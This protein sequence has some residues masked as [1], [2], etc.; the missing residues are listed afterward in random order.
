LSSD[1]LHEL[2]Q[3]QRWQKPTPNLQPGQVVLLKDDKTPPLRWP[4]AIIDDV[5]P[6]VDGKIRVVTVKTADGSFKRPRTRICSSP[7]VNSELEFI[8]CV[9]GGGSMFMR[10]TYFCLS[11]V[12]YYWIQWISVVGSYCIVLCT[13]AHLSCHTL[14]CHATCVINPSYAKGFKWIMK[15]SC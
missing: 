3:R 5:H 2:Q 7:H 14:Y 10:G 12:I 9:G 6:G 1:Y 8:W 4:T 13:T 15:N 11:G